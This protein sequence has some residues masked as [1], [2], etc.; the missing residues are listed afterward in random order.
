[1][2]G[3]ETSAFGPG[4]KRRL[5]LYSLLSVF[6]HKPVRGNVISWPNGAPPAHFGQA[7]EEA[8]LFTSSERGAILEFGVPAPFCGHFIGITSKSLPEKLG[9]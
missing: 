7:Q 4:M 6:F 5:L 1:V 8:E 2:D 9:Q 3:A